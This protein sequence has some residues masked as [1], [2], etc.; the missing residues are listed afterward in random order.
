MPLVNYYLFVYAI[1]GNAHTAEVGIMGET[2]GGIWGEAPPIT[3]KGL[4]QQFFWLL[5][6]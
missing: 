2:S 4:C 1:K 3:K 6:Y 5:I